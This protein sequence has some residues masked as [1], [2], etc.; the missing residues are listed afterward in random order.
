MLLTI[1]IEHDPA[2]YIFFMFSELCCSISM[3][4]SIVFNEDKKIITFLL[5]FV[6][7]V[8]QS[9]GDAESCDNSS[10]CLSE[11]LATSMIMHEYHRKT[12]VGISRMGC[13]TIDGDKT[14]C[15][16]N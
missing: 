10:S 4:F 13:F 6:L 2:Y 16:T 3:D 9:E 7:C 5:F 11:N 1:L 12:T 8:S 14:I 15:S